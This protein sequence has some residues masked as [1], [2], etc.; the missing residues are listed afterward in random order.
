MLIVKKGKEIDI[1]TMNI[2]GSRKRRLTGSQGRNESPTW[3]PNGRHISFSSD[4]S[5]TKYVYIMT[6]SGT[7]LK[8]LLRGQEPDW[9]PLSR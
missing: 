9:A 2:D 3:S 6:A 8:K 4:R 1:I 7:Q 5:G